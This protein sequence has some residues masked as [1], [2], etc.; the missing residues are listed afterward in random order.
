MIWLFK[1]W[2]G[3]NLY[4]TPRKL[5]HKWKIKIGVTLMLEHRLSLPLMYL[6]IGTSINLIN[7]DEMKLRCSNSTPVT[8]TQSVPSPNVV[9]LWAMVLLIGGE[10]GKDLMRSKNGRLRG[11]EFV[12]IV[13]WS[14]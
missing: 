3:V 1:L 12:S 10:R 5:F 9:R 4:Y 14:M 13:S 7:G 8:S 11:G 2:M 6:R